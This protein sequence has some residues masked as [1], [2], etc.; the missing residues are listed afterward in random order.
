MGCEPWS[1]G[2]YHLAFLMMPVCLFES[3]RFQ[4]SKQVL[5][6]QAGTVP[7]ALVLP[8]AP[9]HTQ[10]KTEHT[11][12]IRFCLNL[13][14][15]GLGGHLGERSKLGPRLPFLWLSSPH[16]MRCAVLGSHLAPQSW[17]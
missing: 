8:L 7:R 3:P 5:Y 14:L 6:F 13:S 15:Q 11:R 2:S 16:L 9:E 10:Q 1:P 12:W 4:H 17:F